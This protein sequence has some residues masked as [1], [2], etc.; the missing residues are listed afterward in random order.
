MGCAQ[1]NRTEIKQILDTLTIEIDAIADARIAS[2]Q[3]TLLNLV[4]YL[5][6]ENTALKEE[7][8][9]LKDEINR[10]K[11]EQGKPDVRK[12][13]DDGPDDSNH[14][15]E[16]DRNKRAN[17]KPPKKKSKKKKTVK[18]DRHITCEIDKS[19]LPDFF[20]RPKKDRLTL[21]D[22]LCR[23]ELKFEINKK[24]YELMIELGLSDKQLTALKNIAAD[25]CITRSEVD[26]FLKQL[27]PNP[28]KH[29][30]SRRIILEA[31]ALIYYQGSEYAVDHMNVIR[32][33]N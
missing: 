11:G 32:H 7:N 4:E 15:S 31:S 27:F 8:Q 24:S 29:R 9:Q 12:Q 2:I 19:S 30:T 22:I 14:S 16:A 10:L 13:K 18:I 28:K 5:L 25:G 6:E 20:T 33:Y 21:V 17:K 26:K 1:M 23:G 3:K